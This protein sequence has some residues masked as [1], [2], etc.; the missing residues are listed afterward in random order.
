MGKFF[1]DVVVLGCGA[2]GSSTI[3]ELVANKIKVIGIDQYGLAH[4][5]GGSHGET[6]AMRQGY[7]DSPS[8][9]PIL[10]KAYL[11]LNQLR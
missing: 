9:I 4:D 11:L 3:Y 1:T 7:F 2:V 8:Y 6:R 5:K 10:K